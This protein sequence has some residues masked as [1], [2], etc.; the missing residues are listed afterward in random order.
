MRIWNRWIRFTE[1]AQWSEKEFC[2]QTMSVASGSLIKQ[3]HFC[4]MLKANFNNTYFSFHSPFI[5]TSRWVS[6]LTCKKTPKTKRRETKWGLPHLGAPNKWTEIPC[7]C[8]PQLVVLGPFNRH[9]RSPTCTIPSACA[10]L[11]PASRQTFFWEICAAV[12]L[13]RQSH[14]HSPRNLS[15]RKHAPNIAEQH[16]LPSPGWHYL[17]ESA[18]QVSEVCTLFEA[19]GLPLASRATSKG[20]AHEFL[21]VGISAMSV[22][23]HYLLFATNSMV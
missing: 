2:D 5:A 20:E 8:W 19:C 15:T 1:A 17:N 22:V 7:S 12:S 14:V 9:Q 23:F 21:W 4:W 6:S 16:L 11:P 3:T 10:A 18:F 13:P